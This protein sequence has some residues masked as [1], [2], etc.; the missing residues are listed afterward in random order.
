MVFFF[1]LFQ[2]H[3]A[4]RKVITR[5]CFKT[6][7]FELC[8]EILWAPFRCHFEQEPVTKRD[9]GRTK[10]LQQWHGRWFDLCESRMTTCDVKSW[11]SFNPGLPARF[12]VCRPFCSTPR[13]LLIGFL[14]VEYKRPPAVYETLFIFLAAISFLIGKW[15]TKNLEGIVWKDVTTS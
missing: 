6:W 5:F 15:T 13:L 4:H 9:S 3:A 12:F 1:L 7:R 2:P 14:I 8:L 11:S 10:M